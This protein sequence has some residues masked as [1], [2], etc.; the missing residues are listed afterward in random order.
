MDDHQLEVTSE[1]SVSFARGTVID[2]RYELLGLL[3]AGGMGTVYKARHLDLNRTAAIKVL[4][5]RYT[6][7]AG[8]MRRFQREARIISKLKHENILSVFGFGGFK[9]CVYLALEYV[10]GSSL[11]QLVRERRRIHSNEA[12]A[13]FVQIAAAMQ[14]AHDGGVLHRD[15]KPDNVMM[16]VLQDLTLSPRV[17]DFG[18]AKLLDG[19]DRQ[20]LTSTGEV[21]GDPRYMSPEQCQGEDLDER[22][23]IYSFGC[24]MYEVLT[25]EV[26]FPL[27]DPVAIMHKHL[28]ARP[29][30]F[31]KKLGLP[32]AIESICFK[33][34]AKTRGQRYESFNGIKSDLER[35]AK[36]PNVQIRLPK[37]RAIS[38]SG[39]GSRTV[40]IITICVLALCIVG[41]GAFA[42]TNWSFLNVQARYRLAGTDADRMKA[43]LTLANYYASQ[44]DFKSAIPLYQEAERF[45]S[46]YH[47]EELSMKANAGLARGYAA[48][49]L[50]DEARL[51]NTEVLRLGLI[52]LKQ[53]K[54][55]VDMDQ[56]VI[57]A[58]GAYSEIE[59]LPAVQRANELA[60][61]FAAR[62]EAARAK[63]FLLRVASIGNDQ[64][65]ASTLFALGK[66]SLQ[67]GN[68]NEAQRY[69]DLAVTTTSTVRGKVAILQLAGMEELA[70]NDVELALSF[71][72]RA[73]EALDSAKQ[74]KPEDLLRLIADCH[75]RSKRF[76]KAK[77]YYAQSLKAAKD[78]PNPDWM[79]IAFTLDQFGQA[80]F[81]SSNYKDAE[82]AFMEEVALL[83]YN[84]KISA[85]QLAWTHC[86]LANTFVREKQFAK[87][88]SQFDQALKVIDGATP[89]P[90]LT[91]F[92]ASISAYARAGAKPQAELK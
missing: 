32:L 42:V 82:S 72:G 78:M 37:H 44:S 71:L 84:P 18:L 24:L 51:A 92:R 55:A 7:D 74:E 79:Q 39:D 89:T 91:S 90:E 16:V 60:F 48:Q 64:V 68:K 57:D 14:H 86:K 49:Q 1:D 80:A 46:T 35:L 47:D 25:G 54:L 73:R 43:S 22:S 28:S 12:V 40:K 62:G 23:D 87:A 31:A 88:A 53:G 20:R 17:V 13:Y 2:S 3:G 10:E 77:Y 56:V 61:A 26:P 81:E 70:H 29:E 5:P 66:L 21:V 15:L 63:P 8:A 38:W 85:K 76:D 27:E 6:A 30:P 83:A 9:D 65:R 59:A 36:D 19:S 52:L 50:R 75:F 67:A 45:A 58:L 69:F 33:A 4:H 34:M 11:G 41:L